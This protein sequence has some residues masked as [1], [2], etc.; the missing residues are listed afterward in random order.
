MGDQD[1]HLLYNMIRKDKKLIHTY[2]QSQEVYIYFLGKV[3]WV[4]SA[5]IIHNIIRGKIRNFRYVSQNIT[6][7][8]VGTF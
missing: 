2:R 5:E 1:Q 7:K 8:N 6:S 4:L 3:K